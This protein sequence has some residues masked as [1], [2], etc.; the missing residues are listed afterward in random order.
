MERPV[1]EEFLEEVEVLRSWGGGGSRAEVSELP[2]GGV[3]S[4]NEVSDGGGVA[5]SGGG[6]GVTRELVSIY[7]I[8][9]SHW[10]YCR[11]RSYLL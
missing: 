4:L 8:Y 6:G 7:K 3:W 2:A 5:V 9:K 10:R 1:T 11:L